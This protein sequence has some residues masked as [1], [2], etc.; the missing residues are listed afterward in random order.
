MLYVHNSGAWHY[1]T[2]ACYIET[3][4][5]AVCVFIDSNESDVSLFIALAEASSI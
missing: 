4:I 3:F 2:L 1:L 5:K